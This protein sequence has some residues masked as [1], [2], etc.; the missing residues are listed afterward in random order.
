MF[1]GLL[2]GFTVHKLVIRPP[3]RTSVIAGDTLKTDHFHL[4]KQSFMS[5]EVV[6]F[7]MLLGD[8]E[9]RSAMEDGEILI[10][11]FSEHCL[12]PASYDLRVG[13]KLLAS[14]SDREINLAEQGSA[15]IRAGEFALLNTFER[16]ELSPSMAA[17]IGIRS[18]YTRKGLILLAG[19]QVDPGYEGYLTLGVYNASPR[20]FTLE[21][22]EPFS[23][24]EFHGLNQPVAEPY[25]S[26]SAQKS[27]DIPK[28]DKD[29]LR[30][31]ETESLS[32]MSESVRQLSENMQTLTTITYKVVLPILVL[33]FGTVVASFVATVFF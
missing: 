20:D 30:T 11:E 23:T 16:L 27:A 33:I 3:L 29:Y 1:L 7:S 31:L 6:M 19:S 15:R 21:Y 32:E 8:E 25:E 12:Q 9:I 17:S 14:H 26:S 24:I 4:A 22:R 5:K 10:D 13:E 28:E 2:A 18:Y